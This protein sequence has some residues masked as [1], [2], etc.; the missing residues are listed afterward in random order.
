MMNR[1][2]WTALLL[3]TMSA[4]LLAAPASD[5][6]LHCIP[7]QVQFNDKGDMH[8]GAPDNKAQIFLVRSQYDNAL[9]LDFLE[10]HVG[11]SAGLSQELGPRAWAVY[12]YKS[13]ADTLRVETGR[14]PPFWS[15]AVEDPNAPPDMSPFKSSDCRKSVW[16]C[17][18]SADDAK[19]I[20]STSYQKDAKDLDYSFWLPLGDTEYQSVYFLTDLQ[21]N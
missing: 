6:N 21:K 19:T 17:A 5:G 2:R 16:I 9:V 10:G 15:C 3:W 20:L 13:T 1:K 18:L 7:N 14:K 8:F 12:V 11:A 4:T